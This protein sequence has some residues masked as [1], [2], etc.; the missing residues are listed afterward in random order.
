MCARCFGFFLSFLNP[1]SCFSTVQVLDGRRSCSAVVS[2]RIW[3]GKKKIKRVELLSEGR[4]GGMGLAG[5]R[6]RSRRKEG[7]GIPEITGG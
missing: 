4:E 2:N 1:E 6:R 3:G 7:M 5:R